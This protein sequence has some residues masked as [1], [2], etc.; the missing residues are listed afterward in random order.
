VI[1][2]DARTVHLTGKFDGLLLFATDVIFLED[3]LQN[4]FP[5]LKD[6]ARVVL[7]GAK[8]LSNRL[9]KIWNPV[10]RML[11]NFTFS[12]TPM[13]DNE[14]WRMVAKRVEKLDI[15]EYFLGLMFLAWGSVAKAKGPTNEGSA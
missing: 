8:T 14:P 9:A 3:A 2:A 12:T 4:I 10:L 13:P 7:F 15:E 5:H 11:L 1:Q 6:G